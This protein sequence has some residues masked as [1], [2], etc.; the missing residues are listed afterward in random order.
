MSTT[1]EQLAART[2]S[3]HQF[4]ELLTEATALNGQLVSA[5]RLTLAEE[6]RFKTVAGA[7][8]WEYGI[9]AW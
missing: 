5:G 7:L 9:D 8:A 1:A 6:R 2:T 3:Q 4:A